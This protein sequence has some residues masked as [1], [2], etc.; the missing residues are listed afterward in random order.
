[1]REGTHRKISKSRMGNMVRGELI[2]GSERAIMR[3]LRVKKVELKLRE[4]M[5]TGLI[6]TGSRHQERDIYIYSVDCGRDRRRRRKKGF[7]M[8]E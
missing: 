3:E 2:G 6:V 4:V 5:A 1:M 7:K 8:N